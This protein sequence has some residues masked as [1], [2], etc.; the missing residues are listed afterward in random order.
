[1]SSK[2]RKAVARNRRTIYSATDAEAAEQALEAFATKWDPRFPSIS[3]SGRSRWENIIP[4][5]S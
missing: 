1:V 4:F 2:E 3:K 5:F